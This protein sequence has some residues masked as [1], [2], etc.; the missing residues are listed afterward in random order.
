MPEHR[1]V[2]RRDATLHAEAV[3]DPADPALLLLAG[4]SCS[5][6]WW[7]PELCAR[8]AGRG[9]FVIRF[10]QRDTGLSSA[11]PVGD[12]SYGPAD[13]V[14]DAVAVLDAYGVPRATWAGFSQGGWIAQLAAL[15]HPRRVAALVLLSSRPTA[16]GPADADLP[17]VREEL[18][19]A[20]S[21][22]APD[23][24]WDRPDEV[25]EYLVSGER[26]LA[27]APFDEAAARAVARACV[28]RAHQV[29]AAVTNHSLAVSGL[30]WRERLG[31]VTAPT[32]V[33]HG[34]RDPLFPPGNAEALAREI[35]GARLVV[36]P[37]VGHELPPRSWPAVVARVAGHVA[38]TT[39]APGATG[40]VRNPAC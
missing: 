14:A 8:L 10:D 2:I 22:P 31:D 1:T 6:D 19:R 29:R 24:D 15:D 26:A 34:D 12:P 17:E 7:P 3:G 25:V 18:L 21:E 39:T 33:L 13:L 28:G 38:R 35:P 16:H 32:L 27:A 23:L 40:P 37:S 30:R 11:D 9:L 20:W 36:L 4:T 5:M